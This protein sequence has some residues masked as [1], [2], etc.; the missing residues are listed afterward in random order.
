MILHTLAKSMQSVSLGISFSSTNHSYYFI[1]EHTKNEVLIIPPLPPE[2]K[3]E[4]KRKKM[5]LIL[6][7]IKIGSKNSKGYLREHPRRPCQ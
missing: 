5:K 1:K 4:K 2:K 6:K 7:P 3:K